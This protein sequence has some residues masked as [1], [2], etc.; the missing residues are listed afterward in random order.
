M[1][2]T[3]WTS[4]NKIPYITFCG[5]DEHKTPIFSMEFKTIKERK[6]FITQQQNKYTNIIIKGDN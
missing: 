6:N 3:L 4:K 5:D 2:L 1:V